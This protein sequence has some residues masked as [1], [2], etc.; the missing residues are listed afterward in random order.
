MTLLA[1]LASLALATE[2]TPQ[3][4]P[5]PPPARHWPPVAPANRALTE[6]AFGTGFGFMP[7]NLSGL[8]DTLAAAGHPRVGTFQLTSLSVNAELWIGRM[9]P[10]FDS[11]GWSNVGAEEAGETD[12][13]IT[14]A[15]SEL[16]LGYG[17][18]YKPLFNFE[19]R[20]GFA[21]ADTNLVIHNTGPVNVDLAV[22]AADRAL[23]LHRQDMLADVGFGLGWMI[24][25]TKVDADGV[26]TGLRIA[27][28]AGGLMQLFHTAGWKS[29]GEK[30]DDMPGMY[31]GGPYLRLFIS[32]SLLVRYPKVAH[33]S[34]SS[35]AHPAVDELVEVVPVAP[36]E[37][38]AVVPVAAAPAAAADP[39]PS[40]SA[41]GA[42]P[43]ATPAP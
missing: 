13:T 8:N 23:N 28:R 1:L 41:E 22:P 2:T 9:V 33:G 40:V 30:V 5:V 21:L 34:R 10:G 27:F 3:S 32:P 14:F 11:I 31:L 38:P 42:D 25:L 26:G 16:S 43:A 4:V 36:A 37:T 20:I 18:V 35:A 39:A 17:V 7:L 12:T 24:P 19:P 15:M 29:D 6:V